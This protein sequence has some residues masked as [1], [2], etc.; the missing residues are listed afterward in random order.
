M[1]YYYISGTS[2]GIGKALA[3]LLLERP[4]SYVLGFSRTKS[5]G[6]PRYEHIEIDL[7]ELEVVKNFQFIPLPDALSV[8]L[9][10]NSGMLGQTA[11]VGQLLA[12]ALIDTYN[13]NAVA[14]A[15]LS[16]NFV[17]AYQN[18]D[19]PRSI[20][21][22]SSGAGRHAVES[23]SSYCSTKAALDMHSRVLDYEQR[24]LFERN[25]I[26]V[27]SVAPGIVDTAMQDSI[28]KVAFED[29]SELPR[30]VSYKK[31]GLLT[32]PAEVAQ[33]L[34]RLIDHPEFFRDVL[35]DVRNLD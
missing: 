35:Q 21:N 3:E 33:K 1:H 4:L 6:H 29:F 22:I 24:L 17:A 2:R 8:T 5:I 7:S 25:P 9:I 28:R 16:N 27:F 10:N 11:H 13:V 30:F 19:I 26:R 12:D 31:E 15:I 20:I 18:C 14:P 32:S 34:L 23:W